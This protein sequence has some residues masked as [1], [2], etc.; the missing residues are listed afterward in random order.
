MCSLLI[1]Q[2]EFFYGFKYLFCILF[3]LKYAI[4]KVALLK[5]TF[6]SLIFVDVLQLCLAII[7]IRYSI[8]VSSILK[9]ACFFL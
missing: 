9:V 2:N 7:L 8:F 6:L 5:Y 3:V 1:Y 4:E